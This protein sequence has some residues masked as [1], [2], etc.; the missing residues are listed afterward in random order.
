MKLKKLRVKNKIFKVTITLLIFLL[1]L[2]TGVLSWYVYRLSISNVVKTGVLDLSVSPTLLSYSSTQ[3]STESKEV[4]VSDIGTLP[5]KYEVE[6]FNTSFDCRYV[7]VTVCNNGSS[8]NINDIPSSSNFF[9]EGILNTSKSINYT[10]YL[11]D[12]APTRDINCNIEIVLLAWQQDFPN[13]NQ[14]FVDRELLRYEIEFTMPEMGSFPTPGTNI[15]YQ[16][17]EANKL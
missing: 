1:T 8:Y 11:K 7:W 4:L 16:I 12:S 6:K 2:E 9:P 13:P 15:L 14:G 5:L 10:F 3:D 17:S